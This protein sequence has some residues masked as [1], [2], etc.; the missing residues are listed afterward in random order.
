MG[1]GQLKASVRIHYTVYCRTER[2]RIEW[3]TGAWRK[4]EE[5][6]IGVVVFRGMGRVLWG[7]W[8]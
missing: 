3:R 1:V 2:K 6:Q 8:G 7:Q 4:R 5:R